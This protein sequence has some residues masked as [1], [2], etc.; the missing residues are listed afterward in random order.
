M[1][2]YT[3]YEIC[4]QELDNTLTSIKDVEIYRQPA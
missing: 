2:V 3:S 4:M 1:Y